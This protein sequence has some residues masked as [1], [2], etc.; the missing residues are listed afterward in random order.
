MASSVRYH[1]NSFNVSLIN[2]EASG[3][4]SGTS[5]SHSPGVAGFWTSS[6]HV[7]S[8]GFHDNSFAGASRSSITASISLKP[9]LVVGAQ[10]FGREISPLYLARDGRWRSLGEHRAENLRQKSEEG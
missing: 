8:I 10:N 5:P 7:A 1:S 3:L 9:L 4:V 6:T 2:P